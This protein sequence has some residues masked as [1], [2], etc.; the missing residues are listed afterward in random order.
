MCDQVWCYWEQL[1][2]HMG[3]QT[4]EQQPELSIVVLLAQEHGQWLLSLI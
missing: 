1:E 4:S 2:E 3:T